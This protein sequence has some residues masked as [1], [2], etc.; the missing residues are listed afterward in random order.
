VNG[1]S[2][3]LRRFVLGLALVL[4]VF[5]WGMTRWADAQVAAVAGGKD[6]VEAWA[7]DKTRAS[8]L[9]NDSAFVT[10]RQLYMFGIGSMGIG[11]VMLALLAPR[12]GWAG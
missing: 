8:T 3:Y 7:G 1:F 11:V 4:V 2:H 6:A 5:G 12:G 10:S 9:I